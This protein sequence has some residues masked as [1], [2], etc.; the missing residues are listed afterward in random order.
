MPVVYMLDTNVASFAIKDSVPGLR[1]HLRRFRMNQLG[2][3]VITEAEL[4]YGLARKPEATRLRPRVFEFLGSVKIL[5]WTSTAAAHYAS[6]RA[7]LDRA[8][9]TIDALDMLIAAHALA[10]DM[11]LVTNDAAFQ[12]IAHLKTEDWTI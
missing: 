7:V 1:A 6:T 8:G 9:R 2:V 5:P 11:T 10:E 12:R 3:S 4:R